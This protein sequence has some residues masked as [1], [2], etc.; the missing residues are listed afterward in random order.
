[1][2]QQAEITAVKFIVNTSNVDDS[3]QAIAAAI[4]FS[5]LPLVGQFYN[6]VNMATTD[7][8][9]GYLAYHAGFKFADMT[10]DSMATGWEDAFGEVSFAAMVAEE[11]DASWQQRNGWQL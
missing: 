11:R 5:Y 8:N 3:N 6:T 7:F 2:T 10:S 9:V 4:G 1:M